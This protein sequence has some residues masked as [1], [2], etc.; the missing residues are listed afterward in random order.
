MT[1]DSA[2]RPRHR[3]ARRAAGGADLRPGAVLQA[4]GLSHSYGATRVRRDVDFAIDPGEVVSVM[5]PSGSGK[6]TLLHL[7][8]GPLG[9]GAG[10]AYPGGARSDR[11]AARSRAGSRLRDRG[12]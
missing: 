8:A 7:L 5:G 6:S 2:T 1:T 3:D 4:S 12:A 10:Q 11:L 9:P